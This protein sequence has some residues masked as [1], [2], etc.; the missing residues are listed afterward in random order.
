LERNYTRWEAGPDHITDNVGTCSTAQ[1]CDTDSIPAVSGN[2]LNRGLLGDGLTNFEE[3]RGFL[4]RG[5][6]R[7]AHPDHKDL[8]LSSEL[9]TG[10]YYAYP[11]SPTATHRIWG[12]THPQGPEHESAT[13]VVNWKYQNSGAGGQIPGRRPQ[14][15]MRIVNAGLRSG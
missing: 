8:F 15:A 14:R 1:S 12:D 5:E 7:R 6:H 3:L 4:V 9:T 2:P 10:I 11:A 13:R